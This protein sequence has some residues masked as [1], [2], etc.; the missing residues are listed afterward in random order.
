MKCFAASYLLE[1]SRTPQ[2]LRYA[3]AV[4]RCLS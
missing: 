1:N 4:V 2:P 3:K